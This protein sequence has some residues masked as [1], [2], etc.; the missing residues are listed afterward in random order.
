MAIKILI[1]DDHKIVREAIA[2]MLGKELGMEVVGEA[3]DDRAAVQLARELQ[4]N[5]IIMDIRKSQPIQFVTPLKQDFSSLTT[6]EQLVKQ[7]RNP[8]DSLF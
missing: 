4:P 1:A 3:E 7:F 6:R 8:P 2:S 5:V